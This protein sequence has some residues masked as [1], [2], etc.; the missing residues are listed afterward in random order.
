[1]HR[2][3][4]RKGHASDRPLLAVSPCFAPPSP[5]GANGR[6]SRRRSTV[7]KRRETVVTLRAGGGGEQAQGAKDR[8]SKM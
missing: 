3:P 4:S 5:N 7:T 2:A 8:G 6:D 1:M